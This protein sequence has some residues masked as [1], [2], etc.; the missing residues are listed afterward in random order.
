[1]GLMD[2]L[3]NSTK[4]IFWILILAFGLLWGL[5]DTGAI[6]AVMLGPRSLAEVNGQPITA[7]EYNART[8]MYTQRYQEQTGQAPTLE[9][10]AYY[11]EMAWDELILER[12][13]DSEMEKLGIQVTDD[14]LVELITGVN[15]HPMVAQFFTREDGT[16][17]RLALQA[18]IEAPEN[19]PI[20]I[21]IESQLRDQRSREK[22]NAYI[23][24][25]LRVSDS[26]IE[27]EF[28]RENSLVTFNYVRFPYSAVDEAE[29]TVTESE[30]NS[31]YRS[32]RDKFEQDDSWRF[33][34]VEF[35]KL[36]TTA[37][38]SRIYDEV[39]EIAGELATAENDSIFIA[40]AFSDAPYFGGWLNPS[41][42]NWYLADVLQ[43]GVGEVTQ[44]VEHEGLV[45]VA[46][47]IESRRGSTTYTRVRQIRLNFNEANK[48]ETLALARDIVSRVNNG[49]SFS[50]IAAINSFDA[51]AQRGGEL[52]YVT[53][54][55]L[56][57]AARNT[58]FNARVNTVTAPIESNN[59]Y[60]IY[61]IVDRSNTEVRL[62]QFTRRIEADGGDTIRR[63]LD[64][65]VDF[66]E[67][68]DLDGF[69]EEAERRSLSLQTGF[70]TKD[71]PFITGVGQSRVL[72][73]E[74]K[75]VTSANTLLEPVELD[76]KILVVRVTEVLKKGP[77]PLAEVSAQIEN[78]LRSQKRRQI[79]VDKTK[80]L[81][82][83]NTSLEALASA[84]GKQVQVAS[85]IRMSTNS[86][87][88]SGREP[89]LVGAAFGFPTDA[90]STVIEGDNAAFV[91]VVTEKIE[92]DASRITEAYRQQTRQRLAQTKTQSFQE[93]WLERLKDEADI[94]DYRR[95]YNL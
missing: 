76:D 80:T 65:A 78:T 75:K 29:L 46:K 17:D 11:E 55:D 16:V 21:N 20:W 57:E 39:R 8:N 2:R 69:V 36:P 53:R 83:G 15:P 52:G 86:V 14:E 72:M 68:A 32:N 38:S 64:E 85:N 42:V 3:R 70:A 88:G 43:L 60:L 59:S 71:V 92:A 26:E 89:A 50:E 66:R 90:V 93:V 23:E 95:F 35:S 27:Q 51:T 10:R 63:Q 9:M 67:F 25:S 54:E 84:D 6:D 82:A 4:I 73:N 24:S 58:V 22:L 12:I 19:T 87:P 56:P 41:E 45:S 1:M 61:Q 79:T 18:A 81:L 47:L 30:I 94:E 13:I 62:A 28:M 40:S 34:F 5:A 49:D 77:R 74:L 33:E 7:E 91:I 31:Y 44:P 48:E 37:D